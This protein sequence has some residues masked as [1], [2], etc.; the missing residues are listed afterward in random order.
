MPFLYDKSDT[1]LAYEQ[2]GKERQGPSQYDA[3]MRALSSMGHVQQVEA[4]H[5]YNDMKSHLTEYL[6]KFAENKKV[7]ILKHPLLYKL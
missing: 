3:G 5:G 7:C 4:L 1:I 2:R 6:K